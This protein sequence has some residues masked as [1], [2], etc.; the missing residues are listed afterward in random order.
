MTHLTRQQVRQVD[1]IAIEQ[2]GIPGI[3]LMENAARNAADAAMDMLANVAD[4]QTLILCGGG[5]NGGDG[6]AIA[7]HLHLRGVPVT[8][9]ETTDAQSLPP[10]ARTNRQILR[11]LPAIKV[12]DPAT[13]PV[14]GQFALLID[15]L[16]GTGATRPP[17]PP[18]DD[19]IRRMN[20]S[21]R[22]ILA[23]DLPSGLDCDTGRPLGDACV[24]ATRTVTFV[25]FKAG[26][27]NA[28]SKRYTGQ[29]IVADI[30]APAIVP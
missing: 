16:L 7:R 29:V 3:V 15:A 5:N 10:D 21:T 20:E 14:F 13:A 12:V 22:P 28:E 19:L 26:F 25:A 4:P 8:V 6:F 1:R 24:R 2:F 30:G 11:H 27:A 17:R 9:L 23:V 18:L